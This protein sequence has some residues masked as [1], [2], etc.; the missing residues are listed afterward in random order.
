MEEEHAS[1]RQRELEVRRDL[2]EAKESV[3]GLRE[4]EQELLRKE[5]MV[6]PLC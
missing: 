6:A 3:S 5:K 1:F 2:E 4:F